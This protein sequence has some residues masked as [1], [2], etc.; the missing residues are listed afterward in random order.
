MASIAASGHHLLI[1]MIPKNSWINVGFFL[2][3]VETLQF[4][5]LRLLGKLSIWLNCSVNVYK[6]LMWEKPDLDS[7]NIKRVRQEAL[8]A[9]G[10]VWYQVAV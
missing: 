5:V 2:T 8:A 10:A 9:A 3:D 6:V 4:D 7:K 1:S